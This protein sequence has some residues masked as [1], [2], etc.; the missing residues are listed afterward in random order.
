MWQLNWYLDNGVT[1]AEF[2]APCK[3]GAS[4]VQVWQGPGG[5][6]LGWN[7]RGLRG[8]AMQG[9]RRGFAFKSMQSNDNFV[10]TSAELS[11]V[12]GPFDLLGRQLGLSLRPGWR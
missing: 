4:L 9:V 8:G 6:Q 11:R 2:R 10:P 5:W 3:S 7:T 12:S 1:Q